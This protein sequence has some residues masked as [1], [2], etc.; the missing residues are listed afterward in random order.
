MTYGNNKNV[1]EPYSDLEK[2]HIF[3]LI[4]KLKSRRRTA[5]TALELIKAH[6]YQTDD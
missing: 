3:F 6:K 5:A 1:D 4:S 2:A